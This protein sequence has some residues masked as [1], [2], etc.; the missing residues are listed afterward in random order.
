MLAYLNS[1]LFVKMLNFYGSLQTE[2]D[3]S[4]LLC[5][6]EAFIFNQKLYFQ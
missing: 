2:S 6:K 1:Q 3:S 4:I 5:W